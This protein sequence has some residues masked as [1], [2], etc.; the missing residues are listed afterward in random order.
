LE[1]EEECIGRQD[2]KQSA[3]LENNNNNNNNNK[4][5]E[6]KIVRSN[7]I[8]NLSSLT[9]NDRGLKNFC[10]Q[11]TQNFVAYYYF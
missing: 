6:R 8:S 3:A 9:L 2:P 1:F 5:N 7:L 11:S 4:L 10:H